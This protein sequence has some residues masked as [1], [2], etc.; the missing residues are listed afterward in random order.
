MRP[1]PE[2]MD[3]T[4]RSMRSLAGIGALA[5]GVAVG[6]G[7]YAMHTALTPQNHDRLAIAALF[8]FAHG[9]ALAALAPRTALRMR[10]AGLCVLMIGTI[11]FSGSLVFAALLGIAPVLAPFG[12]GLLMLGWLL[13]AVGYLF[14]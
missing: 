2:A 14:G 7:A 8:L 12:G 10:Q 11:L 5:C 4:V 9:L 6:I 1:D 3:F 13:I